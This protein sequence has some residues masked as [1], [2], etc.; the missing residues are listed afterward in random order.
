MPAVL[1]LILEGL[2]A[3]Q[4][5][6]ARLPQVTELSQGLLDIGRSGTVTVEQEAAIRAQLDVA[7]DQI[8]AA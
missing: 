2:E 6:A 4:A 1:P 5:L 3:I 7:K 8:D